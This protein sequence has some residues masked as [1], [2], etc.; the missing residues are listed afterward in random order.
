MKEVKFNQAVGMLF[1]QFKFLKIQL[2]IQLLLDMMVCVMK[3]LCLSLGC[4]NIY[5]ETHQLQCDLPLFI[6]Q[7]VNGLSLFF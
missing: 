3:T 6:V 7:L 1:V 4:V 2:N 5:A